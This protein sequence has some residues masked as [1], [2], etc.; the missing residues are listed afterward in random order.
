M[1]VSIQIETRLGLQ[2][3]QELASRPGVD[4]LF[5]GPHDLVWRSTSRTNG[6][7]R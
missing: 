2:R 5:V 1:L 3:V 4:V 7:R 6:K